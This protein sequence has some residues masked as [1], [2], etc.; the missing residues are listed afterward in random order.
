[1]QAVYSSSS[2]TNFRLRID[3]VH[4]LPFAPPFILIACASVLHS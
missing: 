2:S 4:L 1:M 3:V